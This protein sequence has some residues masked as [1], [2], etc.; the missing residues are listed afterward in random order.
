MIRLKIYN[1]LKIKNNQKIK[2]LKLNNK[3]WLIEQSF[4]KIFKKE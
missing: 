3:E 1:K 2:L 4:N